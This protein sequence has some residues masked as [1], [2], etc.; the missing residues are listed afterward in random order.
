MISKKGTKKNASALGT[1]K[2][3]TGIVTDQTGFPVVGA[4]VVEKGTT[5]GTMTARR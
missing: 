5:N 4:N 3:I 2:H 1:I